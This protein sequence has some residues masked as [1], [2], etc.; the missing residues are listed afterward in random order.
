MDLM[1]ISKGSEQ[2]NCDELSFSAHG[3]YQKLS[4]KSVTKIVLISE[5]YM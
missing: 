1:H 3:I 2:V 4:I 5:W